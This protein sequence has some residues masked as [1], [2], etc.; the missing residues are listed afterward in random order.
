M[1]CFLE[2]FF[3]SLICSLLFVLAYE[4]A[5]LLSDDDFVC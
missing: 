4:V 3:I 5:Y 1:T 2:I